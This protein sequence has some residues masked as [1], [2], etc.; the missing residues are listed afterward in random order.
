[1]K[2]GDAVYLAV[3]KELSTQLEQINGNII[4]SFNPVEE[5][6]HTGIIEALDFLLEEKR[7]GTF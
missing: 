3:A 1:M 4:L 2:S 6:M 7:K 5:N